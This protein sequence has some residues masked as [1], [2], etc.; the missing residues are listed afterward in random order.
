[1][2]KL[3]LSRQMFKRI[4]AIMVC[5]V[6]LT[7]CITSFRLVTIMLIRGEEYQSKASAQQLHDAYI[8]PERGNIYDTNMNVL[9][10]SATVWTVY[11]TPND[12][13]RV[14]EEQREKVKNVIAD[15]LSEILS[16]EREGII[17]KLEKTSRYYVEI[18]KKVSEDD[19]NKV[20]EFIKANK[21]LKISNYLGIDEA[22]TRYYSE[23]IASTVLGFVGDDNNG[24]SGL[25]LTYDEELT[26]VTG[27][28][29]AAK[30]ANGADMPFSY[31]KI[32]DAEPGNSLVLTIDS[33][34][35]YVA[36]KH[37]ETAIVNNS[38]AERGACLVMNVNTGAV[39]AMATKGDFD[40]N[41][42]FKLS[43]DDQ[44]IVDE[45][46]G[47]ER[48]KKLAELRNRQWRNKII[49]DAYEPGSVFKVITAAIGIEEGFAN[50]NTSCNC[51][52]YIV[53]AG[54]RYSC[55]KKIG[56]GMQN[57]TQATQNSCN[58]FF[59]SLGQSIG[60]STFSKYFK[61]FGLTEKTGIDLVGEA[62]S[63]YHSEK[64]MGP[65]E[66]ASSSFGQTFKITPIQ[67]LTAISAAV[68]GGYLVQP[69]VVDKV[70][71][72]EGNIVKSNQ[73]TVKRQVISK[74]TSKLVCQLM[75]AVVDGGGGQNAYVPGYRIGGKTGTSQ[76]VSEMLDTGKKR[77]YVASFCGVAPIDDPE[78]AM[79]FILDEP[80][81]VNYYGGTISAPPGGQ[82]LSEILPYLGYEP[83][84]SEEELKK[85][86]K[87]VPNVSGKTVST[88]KDM[89]T[90]EGLTYKVVGDGE[91]VEKQLPETGSMILD[92][93][94][95]LLYTDKEAVEEKTTVPSFI[96]YTLSQVNNLSKQYGLNVRFKGNINS[97]KA[98]VS[99]LQSI[100]EGTEVNKGTV[101]EVHFRSN[102]TGDIG[103]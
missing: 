84:Y 102:E 91:K 71:D 77:L 53:I 46:E 49:S 88:A 8:T 92:G 18:K 10:K 86:A 20:R 37:L 87:S 56:H 81:G 1:M 44:A 58:P 15:N 68:N 11:V 103:A 93:G 32:V 95:V 50:V 26:G 47:E 43:D 28:V 62:S 38:V 100:A 101:I 7:I 65:T 78:I 79:I 90:A 73:T 24:L 63:Q 12:L 39:L 61:A 27:R 72:S 41:A 9:A 69:H 96:G 5:I 45:L 4:R 22:S 34:I 52:G 35:Q 80:Q 36:E 13:T 17:E 60:A 94:V 59:I 16:L 57:L 40:C 2:A 30:N 21:D 67:L 31:E 74:E 97:D 85:L 89:L 23:N 64:N 6:A 66:L 3:G 99:Y 19:A 76:K 48:S 55:H 42:P 25:E 54:Q 14:S 33:Y 70:I 98:V 51:P 83:Q 29:V 82:I 75:E